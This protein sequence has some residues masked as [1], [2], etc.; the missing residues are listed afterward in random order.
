MFLSADISRDRLGASLRRFAHGL[1][2][3]GAWKVPQTLFMCSGPSFVAKYKCGRA[4]ELLT[5]F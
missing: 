1:G 4:E 5:N 2:R 3:T